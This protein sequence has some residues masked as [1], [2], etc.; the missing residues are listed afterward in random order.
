MSLPI[1]FAFE[2]DLKGVVRQTVQ[3]ALGKNGVI[4]QRNPLVDVSI[5]GE[6]GGGTSVAF[7]DDFVDVVGLRGVEPPQSEVIEDE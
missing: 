5:G 2:L 4:E 6:D 7:D 1:A 3:S